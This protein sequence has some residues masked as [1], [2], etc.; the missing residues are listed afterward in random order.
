[1]KCE[2]TVIDP[3]GHM[4]IMNLIGDPRNVARTIAEF[5]ADLQG[6]INDGQLDVYTILCEFND[7]GVLK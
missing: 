7:E 3:H 2:L 4:E 6:E 1:M 5:H